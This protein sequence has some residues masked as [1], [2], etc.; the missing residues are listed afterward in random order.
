MADNLINNDYKTLMKDS[1][2]NNLY[3]KPLPFF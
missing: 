2:K 3:R 1:E